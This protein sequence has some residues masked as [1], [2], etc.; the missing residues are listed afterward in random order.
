MTTASSMQRHE[1][2]DAA[3]L[4]ELKARNIPKLRA[5]DI[6]EI[7][8][9]SDPE[10]GAS[11]MAALEEY[12]SHF[13]ELGPRDPALKARLC[14]CCGAMLAGLLGS[15]CWGLAHGEGACGRCGYPARAIHHIEGVGILHTFVLQYHPD[16][17]S[18]AVG[19]AEQVDRA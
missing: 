1:R 13:V 4:T 2:F 9:A 15:F 5:T 11:M 19:S 6:A 7:T 18:F 3:A 10:D 17:L 12:V 8:S 16:E 14:I